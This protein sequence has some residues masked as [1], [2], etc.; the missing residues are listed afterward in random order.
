[1]NR[2]NAVDRDR[3]AEPLGRLLDQL[4]DRLVVVLDE[5]LAQQGPLGD[6]LPELAVD[7]LAPDVLRLALRRHLLLGDPPLRAR[8]DRRG[9][10]ASLTP[11]RVGRG[12]VE[13]H[14]P[15]QRDEALAGRPFE[16]HQ[17]ADLAV[18]VEVRRH[19]PGRRG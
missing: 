9:M 6:E 1:M 17:H 10:S 4:A 5:G 16:L 3:R 8:S 14:L 2:A 12:D 15:A 11:D 18:V 19:R 13:G 7:D